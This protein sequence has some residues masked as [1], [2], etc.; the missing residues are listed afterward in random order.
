MKNDFNKFMEDFKYQNLTYFQKKCSIKNFCNSLAVQAASNI[1]KLT[2]N[3]KDL[4]CFYG[5]NDNLHPLSV[6]YNDIPVFIPPHCTF[7]CCDIN[8]IDKKIVNLRENL[9]DLILMDPP[10]WNKH[11]RR[12]NLNNI[13]EG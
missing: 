13:D 5:K 8:E 9:F 3:L 2:R 7:Y 11:I 4:K 10:W 6:I 1:F 12:K